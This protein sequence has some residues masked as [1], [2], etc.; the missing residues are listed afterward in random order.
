MFETRPLGDTMPRRIA[1]ALALTLG[2]TSCTG[3][4]SLGPLSTAMTRQVVVSPSS[5]TLAP[6]G[7]QQ[8]SAQLLQNGVPKKATFTWSS[9]AP[10]VATVS[11]AGLVTA[12]GDG[13]AII[14]ATASPGLSGTAT[15]T[16]QTPPPPPVARFSFACTH[17]T[18]TFNADSSGAQPGAAFVWTFGDS[19]PP[20]TGVTTTH[21]YAAAGSYA[22][23]LTVTDA[24]GTDD[25]TRVVTVTA[26]P[27]PPVAHFTYDCT[28]LSCTFDGTGSEGQPGLSFSWSFG[29]DTMAVDTGATAAHTYAAAGTYDVT[30]IVTDAGGSDDT[31][32]A[33]TV[34]APPADPAILAT[35]PLQ[36]RPFGSTVSSPGTAWVGQIDIGAIQRLDVAAAQFTGLVPIGTVTSQPIGLAAD[37]AGTRVYVAAFSSR[38]VSVNT[39]TLDEERQVVISGNGSGIA[40]T[41]AGDTVYVGVTTG[42][43]HQVDMQNGVVLRTVNLPVAAG[44]HFAWNAARTRLYASARDADGTPGRVTELDPVNL[45]VLRTFMTGGRPQGI[46]F[47]ADGTLL[48]VANEEGNVIT[49]NV[50]A[51]SFAGTIT[52]GCRGF[53]LLRNPDNGWLY[54]TCTLDGRVVVVDPQSGATIATLA[55]G[56]RPRVPSFDPGTGRIV[57]PNESGWVDIIR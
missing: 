26:P 23:T 2:F 21:S 54:V 53:G 57:V 49:W 13:T 46:A 32:Q 42:P 18:C 39:A 52:T 22:V 28:H 40:A 43:I 36:G 30:L 25:T 9:S 4:D 27:P 10:A 29:D 51:N 31:T 14:T 8:F 6:G 11:G 50:A 5:A 15:V 12:I 37:A 19:T 35:L 7:T 44:Y 1:I 16:V 41:P 38:A 20:D 56:G 17:L 55:T 48:Y 45:T 33:V 47:S 3:S 24:G 34:T